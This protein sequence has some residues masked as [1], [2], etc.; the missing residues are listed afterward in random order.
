MTDFARARAIAADISDLNLKYDLRGI[1]DF[2]EGAKLLGS[3]ELA[4]AQEKANKLDVGTAQ[5]ALWV[6]LGSR[7]AEVGDNVR[8][9]EA[10]N[11]ALQ[12]A[13]KQE[14]VERSALTLAVATG[15][16][17][18]D[19]VLAGQALGEAVRAFN[20]IED[21]SPLYTWHRKL[22]AGGI[23]VSFSLQVKGVT[24]G[25]GRVLEHRVAS[26]P[27]GQRC[28]FLLSRTSKFLRRRL[29]PL[30]PLF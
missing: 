7:Y 24:G 27:T 14:A 11:A 21:G 30:P 22:S 25:F 28:L 20:Q 6:G 16:S 26:D 17:R 12:M 18:F 19:A 3:G 15:F 9:F 10:L 13:R 5:A 23:D 1:I 29:S 8:A 2:S 4:A